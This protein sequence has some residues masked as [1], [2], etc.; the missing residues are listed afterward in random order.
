MTQKLIKDKGFVIILSSPSAA[1]KSS[2]AKALLNIDNNL[3]ISISTT[4]RLP[5][6]GEI[7][8][9]DY[10]FKTSDEFN[11]LIKQKAFL[12]YANVY[13]NNYGTIKKT[14]T[15]YLNNNVDVLFDVDYQGMKSI[16]EKLDNVITIFILPPS[17]NILKQRIKNRGQDNKETVELRM[18]YAV[19]EIEYAKHYDYIVVNDNF[20]AAL[21]TIHSIITAERSKRLRIDLNKLLSQLNNN[22]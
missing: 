13:G 16:K 2:L 5:R 12:E 19:K 21:K 1:G 3:R 10:Y 14:V 17:L 15:D 4:T 6:P 9:V 11:E 7:D 22:G 18:Q 8:K 20:D